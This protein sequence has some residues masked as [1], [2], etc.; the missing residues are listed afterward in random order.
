MQIQINTDRHIEGHEAL[1]V[2]V[3]DVVESALSR[4]SDYITR[5]EVHL[6][7]ENSQKK[8]GNDMRCAMEARLKGRQPIAVTHQAATLELA[9]DGATDKLTRL[10]ES[11]LG[12]LRDQKSR[13]TDPPSPGPQLPEEP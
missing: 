7:D 13:R 11:T 6:S 8:G 2:Q 9:V 10:I 3:S 1:A 5:V 12:R 4:I